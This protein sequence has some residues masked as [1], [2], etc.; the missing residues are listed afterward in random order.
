[1][2]PAAYRESQDR[3]Y[4]RTDRNG[5]ESFS[6]RSEV[7]MPKQHPTLFR[8]VVTTA[9]KLGQAGPKLVPISIKNDVQDALNIKDEQWS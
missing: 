1:M 3:F 4:I 6:K 8:S 5:V 9:Q 2:G 7:K